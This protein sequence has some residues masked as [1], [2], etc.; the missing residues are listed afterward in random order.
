VTLNFSAPS[1]PLLKDHIH[2]NACCNCSAMQFIAVNHGGCGPPT[3]ISALGVTTREQWH[4]PDSWAIWEL[5]A[6]RR[7]RNHIEGNRVVVRLVPRLL[8]T[9]IGDESAWRSVSL[10]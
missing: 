5:T 8:C 6:L 1:Q 3:H 2:R 10:G 9:Q 7:Y 4:D